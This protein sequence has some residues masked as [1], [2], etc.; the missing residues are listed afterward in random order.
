MLHYGTDIAIIRDDLNREG[1]YYPFVR[2][3]KPQL[4]GAPYADWTLSSYSS[5]NKF[6][7]L[8]KFL[9][10]RACQKYAPFKR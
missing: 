1:M 9:T 3:P 2:Q 8:H 5:L 7:L 10:S 6:I 4:A